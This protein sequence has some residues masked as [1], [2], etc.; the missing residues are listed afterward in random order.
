MEIQCI[1]IFA[2]MQYVWDNVVY[3]ILKIHP[4]KTIVA[5]DK[6]AHKK[7]QVEPDDIQLYKASGAYG[8]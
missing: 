1:T 3:R 8:E 7:V 4:D 2:K 6:G 5:Y